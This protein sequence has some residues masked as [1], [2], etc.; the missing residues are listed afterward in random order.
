MFHQNRKPLYRDKSLARL[1]SPEGLDEMMKVINPK[2][3]LVLVAYISVMITG[4]IWGI[5]GHISITTEVKGQLGNLGQIKYIKLSETGRIESLKIK[6]GDVVQK[7]QVLAVIDNF[8]SKDNSQQEIKSDFSGRVLE[9]A[10]LGEIIDSKNTF[11]VIEKNDYSFQKSIT[12]LSSSSDCQKIK[13]GMKVQVTVSD[14]QEE[15][16]NFT[17]TVK[18]VL[19][20]NQG[21]VIQVLDYSKLDNSTKDKLEKS[22]SYPVSVRVNRE[23]SPISF[24]FPQLESNHGNK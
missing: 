17:T 21:K 6:N 12:C 8:N 23:S 18:D 22:S 11:A 13:A 4:I 24:V 16:F 7:G 14:M 3:W 19:S 1:S 10:S 2:S 15:N 5:F 20:L 9:I